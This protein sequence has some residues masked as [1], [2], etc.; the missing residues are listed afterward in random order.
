MLELF[1]INLH[2]NMPFLKEG[3]LLLAC[4]GGLDSVILAHLCFKSDLDITLA[5]CNFNLRGSE[6]DEDETYVKQL[7]LELGVPSITK[8]FDTKKHIQENGGS[9]QMAARALRYEWFDELMKTQEYDYVL[10]A[11]HADDNLETFLI[12]LS[13]GSGIEGLTGIPWQN[14]KVIRPLLNFS[15][16]Q[17][18]EHAKL[19][20]ITWR[21]DSSNKESK[22]LR[23]KVRHEIVPRLKEMH[24]TFLNNFMQTQ[25]YLEQTDSLVKN[26]MDSIKKNVFVEKEGEKKVK[27]EEL[28]KLRPIEAYLYQLF[29]EYG[30][31]DWVGLK[32]LLNATSGKEV[33]SQTHRL[34]KDR[35]WL[36]LSTNKNESHDFFLIEDGTKQMDSP[37]NIK[38]EKVKSMEKCPKNVAFFDKEKLNYPLMLRR[39]QKGDYFYPFGMQGKKK[40]SKYF[41][42]EKVD[43]F[44]KEKQWL[45]C[46]D[47]EIAW[48]VGMRSDNRFK[49]DDSTKHIIKITFSV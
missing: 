14:N 3:K 48:V 33:L 24:P 36:I 10:T 2:N 12:N 30:F 40:L 20:G 45:L 44:S 29:H 43:V 42:D 18:L 25:A 7:A 19:E 23:N 15:R 35:E 8:S 28:L 4:S 49:V 32:D 34:L 37:I 16:A 38:I 13:R 27:V 21:E 47:N 11:H 22:Y 39:W 31:T 17:I 41:K 5:H 46:S 1:K 6:S 9:V 26:H